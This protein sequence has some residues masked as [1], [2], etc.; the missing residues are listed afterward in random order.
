MND[1]EK[2]LNINDGESY[3]LPS[4]NAEVWCKNGWYF[5]FEIPLL[6]GDYILAA[7]CKKNNIDFIINI[8]ESW[9]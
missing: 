6:G 3:S 7:N 2:I 9:T 5:L 4:Y 1:K 8:Y